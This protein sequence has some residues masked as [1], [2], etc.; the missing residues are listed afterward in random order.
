MDEKFE[1]LLADFIA[2]S[3]TEKD[4]EELNAAI[5]GGELEA[6][7]VAGLK[8]VYSKLEEL[9]LPEPSANLR[10]NFYQMLA[11]EKRRE[12]ANK[13]WKGLLSN[14][15][16]NMLAQVPVGKLAYS[17]VLLALG[18]GFG[19]WYNQ[20]QESEAQ[21]IAALTTEMQQ[22]K[23]MLS[24]T[25]LEQPS[26]TDR[27]KAV[28]L[29]TDME[30]ADDK[31]IKALLQT[32]NNDP[33]VNVRLTAIEAL[34]QHAENPIAREGLVQSINKQESPLVQL[35]LADVMVAMQEKDSVQ[36]LKKL[37]K[38]RGLN[39]DVKTKVKESIQVLI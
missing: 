19:I 14:F 15:F 1:K 7:E 12:Q 27:L 23:K 4:K 6:Q 32:L 26:A 17:V 3:Q 21:R 39:E 34:Y 31:V 28:N 16:E 11:E 20:R 30:R 33:N 13:R 10:S 37:L 8:N 9:P 22:M 24:L 38:K 36:Q 25:L 35:A 29:T 2:G 18:V 5:T